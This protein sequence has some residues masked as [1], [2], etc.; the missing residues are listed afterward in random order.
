MSINLF[1][2]SCLTSNAVANGD[3][4]GIIHTGSLWND[5]NSGT[6][7]V[8]SDQA[9]TEESNGSSDTPIV[10]E[11]LV[12]FPEGWKPIHYELV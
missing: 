11:E 2:I 1:L 9:P 12:E 5:N 7:G 3:S 8:L 4:N 10:E 6:N